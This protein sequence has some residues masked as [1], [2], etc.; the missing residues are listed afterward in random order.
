MQPFGG[1]G[2]R[3]H[4]LC[5]CAFSRERRPYHAYSG[6]PLKPSDLGYSPGQQLPV[7]IGVYRAQIA[8]D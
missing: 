2:G 7:F 3:F 1:Y 6:R 8:K 5:D 4:M